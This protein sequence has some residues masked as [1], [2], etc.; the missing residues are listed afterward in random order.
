[1]LITP[2]TKGHGKMENITGTGDSPGLTDLATTA[3][4]FTELSMARELMSMYQASYTRESGST[5]SKKGEEPYIPHKAKLSREDYGKEEPIY[6]NS[7]RLK[8]IKIRLRVNLSR[9]E[10][11]NI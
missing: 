1:M 9:K 6:V 4:I 2:S 7:Y 5:V 8:Y 3:T 10:K 11:K